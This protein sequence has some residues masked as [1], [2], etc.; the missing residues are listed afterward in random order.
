PPEKPAPAKP[1]TV[2]KEVPQEEEK[3][4]DVTVKQGDALEK[5]A[6][7]YGVSVQTIQQVNH[8]PGQ[9][10]RPGQVLK[11]PATKTPPPEEEPVYYTVKSG[12]NP[13][14]IAKENQVKVD[15]LLRLNNLDEARAKRLKAGDRLRVK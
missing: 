10:L 2:K 9:V 8:L 3:Y 14:T 7:A 4:V 11:I 13:W 12:D 5:L 6:R 1:E 15:D